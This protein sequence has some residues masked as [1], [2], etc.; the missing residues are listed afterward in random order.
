MFVAYSTFKIA[1]NRKYLNR[2]MPPFACK[3]YQF[4]QFKIACSQRYDCSSKHT[5]KICNM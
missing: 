2:Q 4:G 1:H 3:N 5:L